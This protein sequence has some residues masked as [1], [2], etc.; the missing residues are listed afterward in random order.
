MMN[1]TETKPKITQTSDLKGPEKVAV[2][3]LAL[4]QEEHTLWERLDEE[5]IKE[6]SLAMAGLGTVPATVVEDI[7]IEF[8]SGMSATGA[9]R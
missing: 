4:G 2:V 7:L 5:E 1:R 8:V 3:M 6:I 9:I